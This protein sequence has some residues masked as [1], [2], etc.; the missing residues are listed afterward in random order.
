MTI[1][2]HKESGGCRSAEPRRSSL[3]GEAAGE[4]GEPLGSGGWKSGGTQ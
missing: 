3:R 2:S 1:Y 4:A